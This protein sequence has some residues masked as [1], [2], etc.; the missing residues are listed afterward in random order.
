MPSSGGPFDTKRFLEDSDMACRSWVSQPRSTGLVVGRAVSVV[1]R[2]S[3][4]C[5][6]VFGHF[7]IAAQYMLL[8]L[9]TC[10]GRGGPGCKLPGRF[11]LICEEGL[12]PPINTN[13]S[14]KR[15]RQVEATEVRGGEGRARAR[16]VGSLP[17]GSE[18][19][20]S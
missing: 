1:N 19:G 13:S 12:V 4:C 14:D 16:K 9:C 15:F 5:A 7:G 17:P 6:A 11:V 20:R 8:V 2:I 18:I 10:V 3:E